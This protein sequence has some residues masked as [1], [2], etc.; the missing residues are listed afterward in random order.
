MAHHRNIGKRVSLRQLV[1][2]S[3][4]YKLEH[5]TS[6]LSHRLLCMAAI[7]FHFNIQILNIFL[8]DFMQ[9]FFFY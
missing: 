8:K 9:G 6:D 4:Y 2:M 5:W 7:G 1:A 3:A